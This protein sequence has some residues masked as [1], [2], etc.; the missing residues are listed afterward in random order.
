MNKARLE[1]FSDGVFAIV[2]TLL[3]LSITIPEVDYDHLAEALRSILPKILS[4]VMSFVLIGLYWIG[5]HFYF[6]RVRQVDGNF[7][8]MNI[9]L[10]LLISFMPFPTYL[11]GKYPF[12]QLPLMLYGFNLIATNLVSFLML[13]Y[14]YK[15]R[16]L[17]NESFKDEFY[18]TQLPLFAGINI[19]Y[20]IAIVFSWFY[21]I[22]SYILYILIIFYGVKSYIRRMNEMLKE[23][24]GFC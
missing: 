15:N 17:A 19:T 24:S 18:K 14:L 3:V 22:V 6:D 7:V 13:L 11:L 21:P 16:H 4:Y 20:L 2:I 8:W 10:L 5:H 9:L 12:K 23:K 1:T